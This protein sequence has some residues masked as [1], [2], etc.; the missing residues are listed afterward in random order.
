MGVGGA[1]GKAENIE[2]GR[3]GAVGEEGRGG[4][5]GEDAK[6]GCGQWCIQEDGREQRGRDKARNERKG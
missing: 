2:E 3:G 1:A 5:A 6:G 4:A